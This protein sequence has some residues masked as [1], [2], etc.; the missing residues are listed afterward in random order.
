MEIFSLIDKNNIPIHI[1]IIMDGNGRWAK[2]QGKERIFGH[3][4]GVKSVKSVI[5]GA[6]DAGV[7][8]LTLYAFST[9]NGNRIK[10]EVDALL[11]LIVYTLQMELD[12]LMKKNIQLQIIGKIQSLS[13]EYRE[14]L[15]IACEETKNNTGMTL[16]LA[17]NYSARWEITE[18]SKQIASQVRAGQLPL[19][20]INETIFSSFLATSNIPDPDI[21]IRTG[22]E[23]RISNFMLWQ[24]SYS[25]LFFL[26]ML[27]PDFTKEDFWQ[28]IYEYQQRERRFGKTSEQY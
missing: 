1:A 2:V 9:E 24:I 11:Y 7:K 23:C 25:E 4:E 18:A 28:I 14:E 17:I 13:L 26:P 21:V 20:N 27:W 3:H 10:E 15:E 8:Y 22:K 16:V 5:E 12:D 19:E 6:N